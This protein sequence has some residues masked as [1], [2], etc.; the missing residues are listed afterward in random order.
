M[1][2]HT[3]RTGRSRSPLPAGSSAASA[4]ARVGGRRRGRAGH[5]P[6]PHRRGPAGTRRDAPVPTAGGGR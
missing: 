5:E 4:R 3:S 6:P 2:T 1:T